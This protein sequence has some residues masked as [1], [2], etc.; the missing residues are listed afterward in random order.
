MDPRDEAN[1][2]G[3][4][5]KSLP[6]VEIDEEEMTATFYVEPELPPPPPHKP[7]FLEKV[8][9]KM[10]QKLSSLASRVTARLRE[11]GA[12]RVESQY[13]SYD[14]RDFHRWFPKYPGNQGRKAYAESVKEM[15]RLAL[16][17][18]SFYRLARLQVNVNHKGKVLFGPKQGT[19]QD[20]CVQVDLVLG[21]DTSYIPGVRLWV[22]FS[23]RSQDDWYA[24]VPFQFGMNSKSPCPRYSS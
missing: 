5:L 9:L 7:S 2:F 23:G 8:G 3:T 16:K 18:R 12:F 24:V 1:C 21:E 17:E 14:K 10:D 20:D 6:D 4:L 19:T 15:L 11:K 22:A 13:G